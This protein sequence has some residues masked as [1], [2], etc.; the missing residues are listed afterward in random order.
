MSELG[1][2]VGPK[3]IDVTE[4]KGRK[5]L[6]NLQ[7]P[8]LGIAGNELEEKVPTE[9][10]LVASFNDAFRRN[11]VEAKEACLCLS[12]K[13]LIIRTF[14]IPVLP[15]EEMQGAIVFEAKKYI[16]F[17]VEELIS[18]HQVEL[19]K[20][21]HTNTVLFIGIKKDTYDKYFSILNQLN[22]KVNSIEYSGFSALRM[23]KLSGIGNSGVMGVLCFDSHVQDEINFTVLDNGFPLFSRDINLAAGGDDLEPAGSPVSSLSFDKL[24]AEIRVSL[25]YY[26]RKFPAKA[27]KNIFVI[28]S[29][30]WRQELEIFINEL[31]LSSKFIDVSKI[32]NKP[33]AFSSSFV[34]SYSAAISKVV[35]TKIRVNLIESREKALKPKAAPGLDIL[36]LFK[37]IKLDFRVIIFAILICVGV[38]VYGVLQSNPLKQELDVVIK[39]RIHINNV[40]A[41]ASYETLADIFANQKKTLDNLD[42][43]IK[44]QLSVTEI[45]G[46]I[47]RVIP[48]GVWLTKFYLNKKDAK[49][50]LALEGMSYL[51]DSN[52]EYEAINKF[53]NNLKEEPEFNKYFKSINIISVDHAQFKNALVTTFFISCRT[54]KEAK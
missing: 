32:I 36:S 37:D 49:A 14:E 2:Y 6:N 47:P 24:K 19:D 38:A 21:S 45:M 23:L 33:I 18:D 46:V 11:K 9:I 8:L 48:K 3:I 41:E 1:I 7:I 25:D 16:P 13:D 31:G 26:H 35:P 17:K 29:P 5:L 12:G 22:I 27:L 53:Y 30:D 54:Y 51:G 20:V 10:K 44:K 43:L 42:N 52:T 34:K 40:D 39:K 4:T 28:S 15:K 50:E